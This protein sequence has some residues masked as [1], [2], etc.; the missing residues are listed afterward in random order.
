MSTELRQCAAQSATGSASLA[1]LARG[2]DRSAPDRRAASLVACIPITNSHPAATRSDLS[3]LSRY[4]PIRQEHQSLAPPSQNTTEHRCLLRWLPGIS[5]FS[6]GS[7]HGRTSTGTFHSSMFHFRW[8]S[9]RYLRDVLTRPTACSAAPRALA[10]REI[11]GGAW[12]GLQGQLSSYQS[13]PTDHRVIH[14]APANEVRRN[15]PRAAVP[16]GSQLV[17]DTG[18]VAGR[19]RSRS[20]LA[21]GTCAVANGSQPRFV[22]ATDRNSIVRRSRL[23]V[24]ARRAAVRSCPLV[25]RRCVAFRG[26]PSVPIADRSHA[27]QPAHP[28]S[29]RRDI[30]WSCDGSP[31]AQPD[32]LSG[33]R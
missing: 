30:R 1:D 22:V 20:L 2:S 17:G 3:A 23:V 9:Y 24:A 31:A 33:P 26:R 4:C 29:E 12:C 14:R 27:H 19:S 21:D 6:P 11:G 13:S 32:A 18:I 10:T 25:D 15:Y 16:A 28:R 5:R 7:E 8:N